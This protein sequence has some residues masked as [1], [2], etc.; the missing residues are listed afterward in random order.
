M[1]FISIIIIAWHPLCFIFIRKYISTY[2][3]PS[4]INK[5]V[6]YNDLN[7]IPI[8]LNEGL[9]MHFCAS[10]VV[11]FP[12][13]YMC[14]TGLEPSWKNGRQHIANLPRCNMFLERRVSWFILFE[15][16]EKLF[17]TILMEQRTSIPLFISKTTITISRATKKM[18]FF[19]TMH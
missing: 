5:R 6:Y 1:F 12:L 14:D 15:P 13:A 10:D 7:K 2:F 8:Y 3:T 16:L 19:I 18:S 11:E 17:H 4:V 9:P